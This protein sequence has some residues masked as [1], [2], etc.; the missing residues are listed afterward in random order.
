[1][2]RNGFK[3]AVYRMRGKG[4][5]LPK[6]R[7]WL[8]EL[9]RPAGVFAAFSELKGESIGKTIL[10]TRLEAVRRMLTVTNN[11]KV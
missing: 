7:A 5:N 2:N 10:H 4:Y 1:M 6:L 3:T 9:P 11:T 8:K